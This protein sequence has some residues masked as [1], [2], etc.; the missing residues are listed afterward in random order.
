MCVCVSE[1]MNEWREREGGRRQ[2]ETER[3]REKVHNEVENQKRERDRGL[4]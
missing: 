4:L 1:C 2:R 3:N